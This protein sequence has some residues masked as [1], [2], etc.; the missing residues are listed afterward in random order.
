MW[1]VFPRVL[2]SRAS[3]GS[4][5]AL[6]SDGQGMWRISPLLSFAVPSKTK[7]L[8][9]S[10]NRLRISVGG[11]TIFKKGCLLSATWCGVCHSGGVSDS[12]HLQWCLHFGGWSLPR[13]DPSLNC[14]PPPLR[15][16]CVPQTAVF[17]HGSGCLPF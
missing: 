13:H 4:S 7:Y 2:T 1:E 10:A 12:D 11:D 6:S 17:N 16:C 5:Q 14:F 9:P 3:A 8:T 15:K